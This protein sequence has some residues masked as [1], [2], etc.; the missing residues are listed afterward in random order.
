MN[1]LD[2]AMWSIIKDRVYEQRVDTIVELKQ[3]I[4]DVCQDFEREILSN[5]NNNFLKRCELCI[6]ENGGPFE[7]LL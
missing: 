1:P 6:Q 2:F 3:R 7:H 4:T 5:I